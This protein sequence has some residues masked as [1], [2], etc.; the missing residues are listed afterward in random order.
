M[1]DWDIGLWRERWTIKRGEGMT[2]APGHPHPY[3]PDG[4]SANDQI[5]SNLEATSQRLLLRYLSVKMSCNFLSFISDLNLDNS[6]LQTEKCN[7]LMGLTFKFAQYTNK[8]QPVLRIDYRFQNERENLIFHFY[9]LIFE[10]AFS[11]L[12]FG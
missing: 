5:R 10:L 4:Q 11:K 2:R 7:C 12:F 1:H 8:S 6:T 3:R 9:N